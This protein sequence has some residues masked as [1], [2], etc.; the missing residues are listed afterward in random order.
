MGL[1]SAPQAGGSPAGGAE[2][3]GIQVAGHAQQ[4]GQVDGQ[5]A[6]KGEGPDLGPVWA[7]VTGR[8][9]KREE[10]P[11]LGGVGPSP[12]ASC[13]RCVPAA[14]KWGQKLFGGQG[15]LSPGPL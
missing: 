9:R 10:V 6:Q 2:A 7:L 13:R 12:A 14:L 3:E 5:E 15:Q 1:P 8:K 4:L 11:Q